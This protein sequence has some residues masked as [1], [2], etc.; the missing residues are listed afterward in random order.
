LDTHPGFYCTMWQ[1]FFP[2]YCLYFCMTCIQSSFILD[3]QAF[4]TGIEFCLLNLQITFGS[5][6]HVHLVWAYHMCLYALYNLSLVLSCFC[7]MCIS[8]VI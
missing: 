2:L 3:E 5:C 4:E 1:C 7:P 8:R 6:H